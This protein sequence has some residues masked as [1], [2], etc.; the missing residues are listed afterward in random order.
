MRSLFYTLLALLG[1]AGCSFAENVTVDVA[2]PSC[3]DVTL[4]DAGFELGK[5]RDATVEADAGAD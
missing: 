1:L 2:L 4:G 5:C 3:V